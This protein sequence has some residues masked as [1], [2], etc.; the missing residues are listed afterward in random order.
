MGNQNFLELTGADKAEQTLK[1]LCC[2]I[3]NG[4]SP[5]DYCRLNSVRWSDMHWWIQAD[6][7]RKK[8]YNEALAAQSEWGAQAILRELRN[9]AYADVKQIFY[10]DHTLKP[11]SDWPAEVLSKLGGLEVDEL[12][13]DGVKIGVTK[14]VKL[15]DKLKAIELM[16]KNLNMLT[17]RTLNLHGTTD[18]QAF[19]DEFFGL[20]S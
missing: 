16:M 15:V 3:A 19:R 8:K 17:D 11:I 10:D 9:I 20:K 12:R 7:D 1:D 5:I 18:D 6:A 14:K 2:H 4:G 13:E